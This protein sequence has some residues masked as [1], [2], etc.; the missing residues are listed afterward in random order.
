MQV[1]QMLKEIDKYNHDKMY[2]F[3]NAR[4]INYGP[5][6]SK[7][8]KFVSI[9]SLTYCVMIKAGGLQK[10]LLLLLQLLQGNAY[11]ISTQAIELQY[12]NLL[13][14]KN[15]SKNFFELPILGMAGP[16]GRLLKYATEHSKELQYFT[17]RRHPP[18]YT[19]TFRKKAFSRRTF[20]I[21]PQ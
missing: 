2:I 13:Q 12:S 16:F 15:N 14:R 5:L 10:W 4:F 11:T 19:F 3:I 18:K 7:L 1:S 21:R 6:T 20:L 9:F 17:K 8:K